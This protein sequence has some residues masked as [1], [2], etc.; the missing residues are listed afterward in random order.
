MNRI[1]A[2]ILALACT[3]GAGCAFAQDVP[4]FG[5]P[6]GFSVEKMDRTADP[7]QDFARYA[8]GRW[9]DAAQIP[10]D[11]VRISP[12]DQMARRVEMV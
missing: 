2:A 4:T 7:R 3:L 11:A 1:R 10:G 5:F 8:S 12:M 9:L 6:L